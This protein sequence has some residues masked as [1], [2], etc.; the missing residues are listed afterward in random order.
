LYPNVAHAPGLTALFPSWIRYCCKENEE[1]FKR[2]A[3]NVWNA[4]T[5]EDGIAKMSDKFQQWGEPITLRELNI[6]KER[7]PELAENVMGIA[8]VIG[9]LRILS[10]QDIINIYE[11]AF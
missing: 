4:N 7:I 9:G 1:Q 2:W 8:P 6:D 10:K 3:K 11:M 5:I